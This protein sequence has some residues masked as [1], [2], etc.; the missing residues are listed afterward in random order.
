MGMDDNLS[1]TL[2]QAERCY[3]ANEPQTVVTMEMA[4]QDVSDFPYRDMITGEADLHTL[5]AIHQK[6]IAS[7]ID[8]LGRR[9]MT[10][11]WLRATAAQNI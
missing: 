11:R 5:A 7:E 1:R 4:Q 9:R 8:N 10:K 6:E 2:P 3:K